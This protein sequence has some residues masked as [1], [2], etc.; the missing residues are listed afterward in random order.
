MLTLVWSKTDV[1]VPLCELL[2]S[3]QNDF[4]EKKKEKLINFFCIDA[5]LID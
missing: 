3:N 4:G 1:A 5:D 2:A